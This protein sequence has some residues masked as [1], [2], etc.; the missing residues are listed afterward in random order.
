MRL[1]IA[2][3]MYKKH[4]WL[5]KCRIDAPNIVFNHFCLL[6]K[7]KMRYCKEPG[8][9]QHY[10]A[11]KPRNPSTSILSFA[12]QNTLSKTLVRCFSITYETVTD[13]FMLDT[14]Y[15]TPSP[16]FSRSLTHINL[17]YTTICKSRDGVVVR[18]THKTADV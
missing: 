11:V 10:H 16:S 14:N 12:S 8:G 17:S 4:A 9:T 13:T 15:R 3:F 5:W 6:N 1:Y 18:V 7:C 2:Y